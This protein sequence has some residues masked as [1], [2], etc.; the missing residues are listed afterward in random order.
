MEMELG[1]KSHLSLFFVL[2]RGGSSPEVVVPCKCSNGHFRKG[3]Y[4]PRI[5]TKNS[6][7]DK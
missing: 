4:S 2:M 6:A 7:R 1:F 5:I 3:S